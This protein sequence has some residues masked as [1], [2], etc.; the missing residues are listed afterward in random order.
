MATL[1]QCSKCKE[2]RP[3]GLYICGYC[4]CKKSKTIKVNPDPVRD[5]CRVLQ[6]DLLVMATG[7][8]FSY[9]MRVSKDMPPDITLNSL[10]I[11]IYPEYTSELNAVLRNLQDNVL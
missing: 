11:Y 1:R 9:D 6:N 5:A 7:R 8:G 2:Y 4:G 3:A 10:L